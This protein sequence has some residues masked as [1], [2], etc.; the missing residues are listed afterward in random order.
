MGRYVYIN[1]LDKFYCM[2]LK[3]FKNIGSVAFEL[4]IKQD[5]LRVVKK[6]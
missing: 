2:K 5:T 3:M 4:C 6:E 1:S